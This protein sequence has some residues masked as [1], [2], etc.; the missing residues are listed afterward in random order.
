MTGRGDVIVVGGGVIGASVAYQLAKKG[1]KVI[2]AEK[3]DF[4]S[5]ASGS[6][7]TS[8]F[9]QSKNAGIHLQLALASAELFKGLKEELGHDIEY[10]VKGGMILIETAE[11]LKVMEGFVARQKK[12]G[13]QVEIIDRREAA[14]L[15]RG[16][17]EHLV[18]STYSPQDGDVNPIELTLGFAKAARRLGTE[19]LLHREVT[20]VIFA[21]GR[22]EG[23]ETAQGNLFAPVVVNAAGAW[24]PLV[25]KLAGLELPIFPR[26]GQI[27]ITE[28]VAPY[29]GQQILSASYI[30]AKY[31]ADKLKDSKDRAVQLGVGLSL[32]QTEKGNIFIGGTREFVG[33][34][35]ANTHEAIGTVLK[36]A[37]RLVPGLGSMHI[38]RTMGGLRPYTPDGLP[39]IGFVDGRE[40]YFMAAGHEGDG[41]ALSPI[42]GKIVA[43][44]ICDGKS[45]MD[46]SALSPN[47]FK[48]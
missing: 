30:V 15:Q 17:A 42:T 37:L 14:K 16:L 3:G 22:V 5:G 23:V 36:N 25:G 29:I 43:D 10:H 39:L 48:L 26:R 40:G 33:Y 11:E 27:M 24:A 28:P 32:S 45:F 13:L 12:T 21:G 9:L 7:D 1:R 2:L 6:C 31:N 46:L 44:L 18:G 20:G 41:I 19:I 4:A 34:D 38:I 8:I 35:A 47:R